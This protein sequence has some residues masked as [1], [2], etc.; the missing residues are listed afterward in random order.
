MVFKKL[1]EQREKLIVSQAE[2]YLAEN[3]DVLDWTRARPFEGRGDGFVFLS[4]RR[5]VVHWTGRTDAPGSFEWHEVH[6]WGVVS[7]TAGGPVLAIETE[8]GSVCFVQLRA[9]TPAMAET[10]GRFV[11]N[12]ASLA[13]TPRRDLSDG[14][15]IGEFQAVDSVDVTH[16]ARGM[17]QKVQRSVVTVIGLAMILFAILIIPLP[18]PWSILISIAGFAI[19]ASE[20]DWAKDALGWM[21]QKYQDAKE[22]LKRRRQPT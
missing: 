12:F 16:H 9:D 1:S 5:I 2:P 4:R 8:D 11:E 10:V 13:P 3:E 22:K 6:A 17:T 15:H 21:R 7:E 19:L 14:A 18:G 20:Y